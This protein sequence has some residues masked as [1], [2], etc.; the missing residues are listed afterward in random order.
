MQFGYIRSHEVHLGVS[1]HVYYYLGAHNI[2][3]LFQSIAFG[4]GWSSMNNSLSRN[5]IV[6]LE[7]ILL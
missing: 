4:F 5:W 6:E 2:R 3:H 7:Y 1:Q